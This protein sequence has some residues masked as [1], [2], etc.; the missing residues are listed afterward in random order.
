MRRDGEVLGHH[1]EMGDCD[2]LRRFLNLKEVESGAR[3]LKLRHSPLKCPFIFSLLCL[4]PWLGQQALIETAK[5]LGSS[6]GFFFPF[7]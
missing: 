5:S 1:S 6:L 4:L 3:L 7:I 2:V